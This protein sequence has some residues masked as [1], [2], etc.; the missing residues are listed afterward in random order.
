MS[1][2]AVLALLLLLPAACGDG[3]ETRP[4]T[5]D[6]PTEGPRAAGRPPPASTRLV[7]DSSTYTL[8]FDDPGWTTTIGFSYRVGPDTVYI[9]NCNGAILLNLQKRDGG[10]WRDA[11]YAEGDQCLSEPIVLLPGEVFRSDV[12]IWGAPAG[13]PGFNDFMVD[14][15]EGEFRLVWPQPVL[16]YGAS[17]GTGVFGD[18]L[19][20]VDRVSNAFTLRARPSSAPPP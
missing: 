3:E 10:G 16:R 9:V 15:V 11:W 1:K 20:L 4:Q 14:G 18:T 17:G 12:H 5:G 6:D 2:P 7:T 19:P 13:T 8:R